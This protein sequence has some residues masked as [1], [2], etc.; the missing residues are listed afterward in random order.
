[1]D[2]YGKR[3]IN[4]LFIAVWFQHAW[5]KTVKVVKQTALMFQRRVRG[6]VAVRMLGLSTTVTTNQPTNANDRF[7]LHTATMAFDECQQ[8][9]RLKGY[10]L[11]DFRRRDPYGQLCRSKALFDDERKFSRRSALSSFHP[12]LDSH[13]FKPHFGYLPV[14]FVL[15]YRLN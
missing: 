12:H 7:T 6:S 1:M 8:L 13:D 10:R 9:E 5:I 2:R 3:E 11:C 15:R 14:S 4:S